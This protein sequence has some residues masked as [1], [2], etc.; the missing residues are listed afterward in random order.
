M[1]VNDLPTLNASLNGVA[2]VLM[3]LAYAAIRMG[4][5]DLH[6]KLMKAAVTV[7]ALFLVSYL[8]YPESLVHSPLLCHH[9]TWDLA[10]SALP[11]NR[12]L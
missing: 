3:T 10:L 2:L 12:F 9:Q 8:C 4:K 6:G 11:S 1:S 5:R 7:S